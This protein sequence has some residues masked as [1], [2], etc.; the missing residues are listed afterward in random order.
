MFIQTLIQQPLAIA[1]IDNSDASLEL[2]N[3]VLP[4]VAK[5]VYRGMII[6]YTDISSNFGA[7]RKQQGLGERVPSIAI[8]INHNQHAA[9]P[10]DLPLEYEEIKGFII[11]VLKG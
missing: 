10:A 11:Q 9:F 3:N 2:V 5:A 7:S 8:N 1:Y 6:C 4:E